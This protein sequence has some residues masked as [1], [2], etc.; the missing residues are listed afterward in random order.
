MGKEHVPVDM[1]VAGDIAAVAKIEEIHYDAVL[2]HRHEQDHLRLAPIAF[3]RPMAALAISPASRGQEQKLATALERL[4]QED[5]ALRIEQDHDT[6][7]TVLRGMSDLHLRIV[8]E[9]LSSRH[10]VE[11]VTGTPRI[12]YRETISSPAEGHYRHKKQ[13]GGAGQFGEVF[14]RVAPLPRGSGF[15]FVDEV[16]G[17]TIPGQFMPAVEKGVRQ[18]LESGAVAG[19]PLQDIRVTVHDGRHHPVDSKEVAFVTAAR[20]AFLDAIAKA[21]PQILEPVVWLDIT[22][23]EAQAGDI[24]GGLASKRA[25][26]NGTDSAPGEIVIHAHVPLSELTD[27]ATELKSATAGRGR[28]SLDFSH[29]EPVPAPVQQRLMAAHQPQVDED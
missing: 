11:V 4:A 7:E 18:V 3:P 2:H 17:G 26:I 10:G 16:K 20:K 28:Y 13:T 29:Y 15:E 23:P 9:R 14:L 22:A 25:R 1:V 8:L 5:P 24:T 12:P 27:Y 19:Y 21:G 6:H